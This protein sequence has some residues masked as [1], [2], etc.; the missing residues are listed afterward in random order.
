MPWLAL[1]GRPLLATG[2][3]LVIVWGLERLEVP[4]FVAL[5]AGF[6]AYCAILFALRAFSGEEFAVLRSYVNR[7][8]GRPVREATA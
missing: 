8:L 6:V 2:V 4:L 1:L 3:N 7:R 5:V